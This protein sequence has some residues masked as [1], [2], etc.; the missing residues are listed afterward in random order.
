MF[1][2]EMSTFTNV[3]TSLLHD[4]LRLVASGTEEG[5]GKFQF[6]YF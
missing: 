3:G 5:T 4:E 2:T 1:V 6:S